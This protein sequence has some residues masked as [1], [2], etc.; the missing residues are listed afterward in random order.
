M[1]GGGRKKSWKWRNGAMMKWTNQLHKHPHLAAHMSVLRVLAHDFSFEPVHAR[2]NGASPHHWGGP[3]KWRNETHSLKNA[4]KLAKKKTC[5]G[6][7][8]LQ[9]FAS[10]F[11]NARNLSNT[12]QTSCNI[13]RGWAGI[14]YKFC[15]ISR[16]LLSKSFR[17]D[18]AEQIINKCWYNVGC[19]KIFT[20][21]H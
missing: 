13:F 19:Y 12:L 1:S 16:Q 4:S 7:Q 21:G 15:C 9:T 5:K 2:K 6:I 8:G 11:A 20:L 17:R 3:Q 14:E 18:F 10:C